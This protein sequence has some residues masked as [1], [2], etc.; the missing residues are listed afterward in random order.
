MT[1]VDL[2]LPVSVCNLSRINS[3]AR[4][5]VNIIM[6]IS[7]ADNQKHQ[8]TNGNT[9]ANG[10]KGLSP[11]S[12]KGE[13]GNN[14]NNGGEKKEDSG[15][16]GGEKLNKSSAETVNVKTEG[17]V[18]TTPSAASS[19]TDSNGKEKAEAKDK[20]KEKEGQQGGGDVTMAEKKEEE[21]EA[22]EGQNGAADDNSSEEQFVNFEAMLR[23]LGQLE[24]V[25]H[26]CL[27]LILL[28]C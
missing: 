7:I 19:L 20:E 17:G 6:A 2:M 22:R 24:R 4:I 27:L 1:R 28:Q 10:N 9:A 8:R 3:L 12:D 13:K 21:G 15:D 26:P 16:K 14:N 11:D 18:A 5:L 23:D 25:T